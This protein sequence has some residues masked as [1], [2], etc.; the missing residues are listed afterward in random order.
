M[1]ITEILALAGTL[2]LGWRVDSKL[3][4]L[5]ADKQPDKH[6]AQLGETYKIAK[7][8]RYPIFASAFSYIC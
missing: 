2:Y 7:K 6:K 8:R 3:G 1:N 5:A 4:V